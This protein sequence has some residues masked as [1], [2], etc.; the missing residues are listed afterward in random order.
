MAKW[1]HSSCRPYIVFLL[2]LE[3]ALRAALDLA[4]FHSLSL[5]VC[6]SSIHQL[7]VPH[8]HI[9]ALQL[10]RINRFNVQSETKLYICNLFCSCCC[11]CL[12]EHFS[13]VKSALFRTFTS[14]AAARVSQRNYT[15]RIL[16]Y[17]SLFYITWFS[18]AGGQIIPMPIALPTSLELHHEISNTDPSTKWSAT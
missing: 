2:R 14:N 4:L 13:S 10:L 11:V 1:K 6:T 8:W 16:L 15:L 18:N 5:C 17:N 3:F 7:H 9:F 12:L